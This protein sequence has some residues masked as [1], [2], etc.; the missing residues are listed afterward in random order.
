MRQPD[1]SERAF[2]GD[3]IRVD[4]ERWPGIGTYEVVRRPDA[5]AVLP[6]TPE[7]DVLLVKQFRPPLRQELTE[8]PAGLLDVAGEDALSCAA[9]ELYEETGYRHETIEFLAG[10]FS[11][12]GSSDEYSTCSWPGPP[13]PRLGS[14]KPGYSCCDYPSDRWSR[15]RRRAGYATP[16]R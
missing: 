13:R 5:A 2:Q 10:F 7:G 14:P 15:P 3:F 6:V 12:A 1:S 4:V 16:R 9:R 8:I 11:S